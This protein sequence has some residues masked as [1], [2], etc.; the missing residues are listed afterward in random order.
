MMKDTDG[1]LM[2]AYIVAIPPRGPNHDVV[3]KLE[4][5]LVEAKTGEVQSLLFI[6]DMRDNTV[7]VGWTGCEN[8]Y[9]LAG[10][11]AR[12]QHLIQNRIDH[13]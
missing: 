12:L 9:L 6:C 8:L 13:L 10:H 1:G 11:S 2:D 3:E 4:Q 5:L 7:A